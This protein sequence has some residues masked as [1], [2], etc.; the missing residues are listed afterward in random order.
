[1]G[2]TEEIE[3]RLSNV[4][5]N[6]VG[7]DLAGVQSTRKT[8]RRTLYRLELCLSRLCTTQVPVRFDRWVPLHA[9]P[10]MIIPKPNIPFEMLW[11]M[12]VMKLVRPASYWP[13]ARDSEEWLERQHVA[14]LRKQL[15]ATQE[16][17]YKILRTKI[18]VSVNGDL[19]PRGNLRG[20]YGFGIMRCSENFASK[21]GLQ[22][23]VYFT[24]CNNPRLVRVWNTL[25]RLPT[26]DAED[27]VWRHLVSLGVV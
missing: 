20:C 23:F 2:A 18:Y 27:P 15:A 25:T 26:V 7:L 22:L 3:K 1:M 12:E 10:N 16:K 19:S 14:F 9:L 21:Q 13:A 8:L 4:F 24:H 6:F 5:H 11:M 17:I